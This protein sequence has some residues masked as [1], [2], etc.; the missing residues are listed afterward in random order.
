MS[1]S[2]VPADLYSFLGGMLFRGGGSRVCQIQC[3]MK[4]VEV[5]SLGDEYGGRDFSSKSTFEFRIWK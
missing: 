2:S 1:L 3:D 4:I 5:R